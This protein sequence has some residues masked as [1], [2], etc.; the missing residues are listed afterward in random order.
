MKT[1]DATST[2]IYS[3]WLLSMREVACVP[4]RF[5]TEALATAVLG[6]HEAH[7]FPAHAMRLIQCTE[8][9]C[10]LRSTAA[11]VLSTQQVPHLM[12]SSVNSGTLWRSPHSQTMLRLWC[13]GFCPAIV[14]PFSCAVGARE[15]SRHLFNLLFLDPIAWCNW[16]TGM[17]K[18]RMARHH[19]SIHRQ[20]LQPLITNCPP[21]YVMPVF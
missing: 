21:R 20:L 8:N 7:P 11:G 19:Q 15:V 5:K 17:A 4:A 2:L 14:Q 16:K 10:L 12:T 3:L 6:Q 18:R 13:C 9:S 1:V